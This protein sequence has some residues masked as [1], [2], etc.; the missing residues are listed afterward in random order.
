MK[1]RK[2]KRFPLILLL[3]MLAIAFIS[4]RRVVQEGPLDFG[5]TFNIIHHTADESRG[6]NLILVNRDN[7]IPKDYKIDLITL[8]NG[9]QVDS[10]IYPDLQAMFDD[11]RAAGLQLFVRAG[12]RT[13]E[14]Q[15]ELLGEKTEA[16][17]NEGY[18]RSEAEKLAKEWVAV[19]GISEHQLGLAVDINADTSV[20]SKDAV[21]SW[22]AEN[23]HKYGFIL[24]YP[25]DKKEITG[26]INEPWH[27]RYVGKEAAEEMH[28]SG[29]CLE[30]YIQQFD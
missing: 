5:N 8:S 10:R 7:Y 23:S 27:Y 12:Y 21:Y 20:C 13:Q 1:Q 9:E 16:Y 28:S 3:L 4:V 22:L 25:P 30:E 19:P 18:S 2:K 24:R 6:W 17:R 14:K 15:Q 11:A 29:L 26:V